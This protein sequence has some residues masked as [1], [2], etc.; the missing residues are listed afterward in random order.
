MS[1]KNKGTPYVD[2]FISLHYGI[3]HGPVDELVD[4][5]VKE[6]NVFDKDQ[7]YIS[8]A[9]FEIDKPDLFGGSLREGGL[10]GQVH[11]LPGTSDQ[12]CPPALAERLGDTPERLP[13]FR[14][15]AT[16]FLYG[17]DKS[18]ARGFEV[19]SNMAS[20]PAM[21]ARVRRASRTLPINQPII[22][23]DG[24]FHSNPVSIIHEVVVDQIWGMNGVP[25]LVDIDNWRAVA[26]TLADEGFGLTLTWTRQSS[27]EEFIQVILNHINGVLYFN[28]YVGKLQLKLFRADYDLDELEEVGPD[29]SD[30]VSFRRPLWGETTNEVI[31][32][33]LDPKTK[34]DVSVTYQD[35]ANIAMQGQ[36]VS[37]TREF[38]GIR[39]EVL[40]SKVCAREL[41]VSSTPLASAELK[42]DRRKTKLLPGAVFKFTWPVEGYGIEM[43]VMRVIDIDWG[44]PENSMISVK[45]VEDI[46]GAP[47][48]HYMEPEPPAWEPPGQDPDD[49][50]FD[51]MEMLF[52]SA[53]YSM[54]APYVADGDMEFNDDLYNQIIIGTFLLPRKDQT[55]IMS[56]E[57]YRPELNIGG[58]P[59]YG[60]IG[61]KWPTGHS[62]LK[63]EIQQEVHS[64]IELGEIIGGPYPREGAVGMFIMD[65]NATAQISYKYD[66]AYNEHYEELILFQE[67]LGE[68]RWRVRRGILDTIPMNWKENARILFITDNY[69][70]FDSTERFADEIERYRY[71]IRTSLGL[72]DEGKQYLENTQR[73]DRPYRPYR[74]ANVKVGAT[75][76]GTERQDQTHPPGHVKM[77]ADHVPRDWQIKVTWSNRNRTMEDSVYQAWDAPGFVPEVGQTTEIIILKGKAEFNRVTGIEGEEHT[78]QIEATTAQLE[79]MTIK[80]ISKRDG[81][82]SLTG[83]EIRLL[84]YWKGFGSDWGYMWGGWPPGPY[85]GTIEGEDMELPFVDVEGEVQKGP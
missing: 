55:D 13:G 19:S 4:L 79:D 36:V 27:C 84:L 40:A 58:E 80:V 76:F 30:L 85:M 77:Q 59:S 17:N 23:I 38:P 78:L 83:L 57:L 81:F 35:L 28:P 21:W 31:V 9:N 5:V 49:P 50:K 73:V 33:Y 6:K 1:K 56:Y 69:N 37:D 45:C 53:P 39:H 14:D 46:F 47:L 51:Q 43:V 82:E 11:W 15:L 24:Y 29:N 66:P 63:A 70:G 3:C 7:S 18:G 10:V 12:D 2:Y 60:F 65:S 72:R 32:K 44:T 67:Y 64:I 48:A 16:I 54:I 20:V 42:I 71:L 22:E 62:K 52:R 8:E 25:A 41:A 26:A 75:M 68:G 61:D 74:P 34:K